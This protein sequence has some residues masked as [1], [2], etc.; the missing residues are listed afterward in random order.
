MS[1][2]L[3]RRAQVRALQFLGPDADDDRIRELTRVLVD[4]VHEALVG[5]IGD[6]PFIHWLN[7][8]PPLGQRRFAAVACG[9][10]FNLTKREGRF[11]VNEF[12]KFVTCPKCRTIAVLGAE[13]E[14]RSD[15]S[16]TAETDGEALQDHS[17]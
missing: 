3:R 6:G 7:V 2:E 11:S 15:S 14:A 12:L 8:R 4:F 1:D 13:E 10:T 9:R 16:S 5:D 17:S